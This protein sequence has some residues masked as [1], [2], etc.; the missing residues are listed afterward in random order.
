MKGIIA[1]DL[2]IFR[3]RLHTTDPLRAFQTEEIPGSSCI[4]ISGNYRIELDYQPDYEL[5]DWSLDLNYLAQS[6]YRLSSRLETEC[7]FLRGLLFKFRTEELPTSI[8]V[9]LKI[10]LKCRE[11]PAGT[12]FTISHEL[13]L[14]PALSAYR[15]QQAFFNGTLSR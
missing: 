9:E 13:S 6:R 12:Q 15:G 4:D 10:T 2:H 7:L 8:P 3:T 14:G 5:I 1:A 11:K